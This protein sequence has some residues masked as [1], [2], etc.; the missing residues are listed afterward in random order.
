MHGNTKEGMATVAWGCAYIAWNK[1]YF[2]TGV[3]G[4]LKGLSLSV[5][6]SMNKLLL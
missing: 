4:G 5:T 1:Y 2:M 3:G 6:V